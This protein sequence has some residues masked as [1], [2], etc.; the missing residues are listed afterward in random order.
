MP[1]GFATPLKILSA[2]TEYNEIY[3]QTEQFTDND[4][5]YDVIIEWLSRKDFIDGQAHS[6]FFITDDGLLELQKYESQKSR[7]DF[8]TELQFDKLKSEVYDLENKLKNFKPSN[9]KANFALIIAV[10]SA[11]ISVVLKECK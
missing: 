1:L 10:A 3:E 7:L 5:Q 2:T 9:R 8:V 6:G 11:I 4:N